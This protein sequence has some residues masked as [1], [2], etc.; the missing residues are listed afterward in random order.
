MKRKDLI[1]KHKEYDKHINDWN[2]YHLAYE[3]GVPFVRKA[4]GNRNLRESMAN[5]RMRI[6]E[7]ICFNYTEAIVD[8]FNFYL[9]E[10][11]AIRTIEKLKKD[12][13]WEMFLED[14]DLIGTDFDVFM[15]EAQKLASVFGAVGILTNKPQTNTQTREQ[16]IQQKIYPYVAIFTPP[17][18]IDWKFGKHPDSGRP[19]LTYLKLRNGDLYYLWWPNKWETWEDVSMRRTPKLIENGDNPLGEIPFTWMQNVKKINTPYLGKSDIV[20]ISKITASIIRDISMGDEI[21]KF[22]GFPIMRKPMEEEGR[23]SKDESGPE[24]VVEFDPSYGDYGKAD[25]MKTEVLEPIE[26]ILK[27]TDRKADEIYRIAH[28]SGVHGQRKSNNKNVG[29]G[30]ALRYEYGQLRSVLTKKSDSM[31]EAE[32]NIVRFFFVWQQTEYEDKDI[33]IRRSKEFSI[34]DLSIALENMITSM[35]AVVS[36]K[37][38]ILIQQNI[39][40]RT[41][42]DMSEKDK[43][44][45]DKEITGNKGS[46]EDLDKTNIEGVKSAAKANDKPAVK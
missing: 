17:N 4:I 3:G 40:K 8:L 14:C 13:Q 30:L 42:P 27:W 12:R 23:E 6:E 26:A 46:I 9:T 34:D 18:I 28:L 19:I 25:W 44:E 16:E 10:K 36:K 21:I 39:A 45:V 2:F 15:N 33:D 37:Y 24:A 43:A 38:R 41:L 29:S 5:W 32:R 31:T 11:A 20:N 22:A 1:K 35:K 7:G